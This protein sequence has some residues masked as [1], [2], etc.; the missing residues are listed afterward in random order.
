MSVAPEIFISGIRKYQA[1]GLQIREIF[2]RY[3]D[4]IETNMR[5]D[6]GL[7]G[8][9]RKQVGIKSGS[10]NNQADSARYLE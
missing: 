10:Q 9:N 4:L 7:S 8:C 6:E 1:V 5:I 3:P 2:E